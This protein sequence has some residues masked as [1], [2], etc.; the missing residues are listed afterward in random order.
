MG[1]DN[2]EIAHAIE[3]GGFSTNFHDQGEGFPLLLVHGSG[4]GVSAWANWRGVIPALAKAHRVVAPDMVGFGFT[5]RPSDFHYCLD[6]WVAQLIALMDKL[7]IDQADIIGNSFGGAVAL[8][9]CIKHPERVRKLV[10]MGSVGISF[11][12][13][14]GLDAVWGYTPSVENMRQLMDLFAWDRTLVNDELAALRY[15]ASI[16]PG[17]QESYASMFPSPRQRWVDALAS[18]ESDIRAIR[19]ATL[20]I[21]GRNDQVIPLAT[22]LT[23]GEWIEG[24]E[25]H[26]FGHCGHWTQIEK[27]QRFIELVTA[28]LH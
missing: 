16:R 1:A 4:P 24:A 28:F 18:D 17:V 11:A 15:Q 13:S 5:E 7:D 10:L 19:K 2:P 25:L 20:I 12:L 26:V 27:N 21:H 8:A 3:T 9:T 22:S 14:P 23:L 6:N